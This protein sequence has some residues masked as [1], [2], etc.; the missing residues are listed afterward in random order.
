MYDPSAITGSENYADYLDMSSGMSNPFASYN[1]AQTAANAMQ[2]S[3]YFGGT[4][5]QSQGKLDAMAAE[6]AAY[7]TFA[8]PYGVGSQTPFGSPAQTS[9]D[10]SATTANPAAANRGFNPWSM[11][12]E[13]N[14]R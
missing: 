10:K 5:A 2:G 4:I 14:A 6:N 11:I 3:Q 7:P 8:N 13:S 12:G 1:P 9:T